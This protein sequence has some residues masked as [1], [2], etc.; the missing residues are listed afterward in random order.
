MA[1]DKTPTHKRIQRA[2]TGRDDWKLKATLRREENEKLKRELESKEAALAKM[3]SQSHGLEDQLIASN[4]KIA[5]QDKL[6][7][8]LKKKSK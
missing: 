6:I 4:K 5:E 2:E 1:T 3:I 8:S 7:E